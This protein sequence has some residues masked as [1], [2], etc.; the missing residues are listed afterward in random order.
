MVVL[1]APA[2]VPQAKTRGIALRSPSARQSL[3]KYF[4]SVTCQSQSSQPFLQ[5]LSVRAPVKTSHLW[6]QG[7]TRRSSSAAIAVIMLDE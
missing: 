2:S 5:W 4:P 7:S 3:G 1:R 6:R